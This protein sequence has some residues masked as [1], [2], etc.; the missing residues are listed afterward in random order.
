M[1]VVLRPTNDQFLSE[2][3]FPALELGVV[4][5]PAALELILRYLNDEETRVLL[6][7]VLE[8]NPRGTLS[9]L[10]DDRWSEAVYRMLFYDWLRDSDGWIIAQ[11]FTGYAGS[12]EEAFHLSLM[13]EDPDYPYESDS[14]GDLYRR[15]FWGQPKKLHG[16]STLM[17]GAWD[18]VPPFP[19]DEVLTSEGNGMYNPEM[20]IARADWAWRPMLTVSQWAAKM[21]S[22]L[23][24]LLD[25]EVRRLRPIDAPERHEV[26]D[27]WLG[28]TR[29]P[30]LLAVSF[31]G[32]GPRANE[33]IRDI[34][35]LAHLIRDAAAQQQGL[36]AVI[37]RK[38][39][40]END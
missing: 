38:G 25:R 22:A 20:G 18:P 30:P 24:R 8:H 34:G 7:L 27:Y 1:E 29:D 26:I 17:C 28:R 16:L 21:P 32:L 37:S 35:A 31:S 14:S 3:V 23:S 11:P 4:E 13:L 5:A 6:E 40:L 10:S 12:W 36:S 39:R 9:E 33:W 19:P 15:S 2:V